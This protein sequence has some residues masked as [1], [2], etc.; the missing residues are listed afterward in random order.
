MGATTFTNLLP[1]AVENDAPEKVTVHAGVSSR[2]C[3]GPPGTKNR[4]LARREQSTERILSRGV[5]DAISDT[6][7]LHTHA[8]PCQGGTRE[9]TLKNGSF[10]GPARFPQGVGAE[11]K[12]KT[13]GG[14]T[15]FENPLPTAVENEAPEKVTVHAGVSSRACQGP[16]GTDQCNFARRE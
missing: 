5:R 4:N 16:T 8:P 3:Q 12:K 7:H 14:A 6:P 15:T 9:A 11:V 10:P 2:G 13:L 1:T